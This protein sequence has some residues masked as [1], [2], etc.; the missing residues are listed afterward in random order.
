MST[1]KLIADHHRLT[2][3]FTSRTKTVD[4]ES[5]ELLERTAANPQTDE[6]AQVATPRHLLRKQIG[7]SLTLA[8]VVLVINFTLFAWA[9]SKTRNIDGTLTFFTGDCNRYK[10]LSITITVIINILSTLLLGAS[11]NAAQ[12][13]TAPTRS[14][15]DEA[16]RWGAWLHIG[17]MSFHNLGY[18]AWKRVI[19]WAVLLC[20]SL[21]L[22]LLYVNQSFVIIN[23]R[24]V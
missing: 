19:L 1:F 16:H 22:H 10:S 21:P 13:I 8:S 17:T 7:L 20:S 3:A 12:Y 14:E 15:I 4:G 5:I 24:Y 11:N 18:I 23:D 9:I 6:P 2:S